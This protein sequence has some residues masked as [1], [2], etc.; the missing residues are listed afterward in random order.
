MENLC[1]FV[2]RRISLLKVLLLVNFGCRTAGRSAASGNYAHP[3]EVNQL[4]APEAISRGAEIDPGSNDPSLLLLSSGLWREESSWKTL[5]WESTDAAVVTAPVARERALAS[6][7][8]TPTPVQDNPNPTPVPSSSDLATPGVLTVPPSPDPSTPLPSTSP[9][10]TPLPSTAPPSTSPPSPAPTTSASATVS[11]PAPDPMPT[12]PATTLSPVQI[13]AT[14]APSEAVVQSDD[15]GGGGPDKVG[16]WSGIVEHIGNEMLNPVYPSTLTPGAQVSVTCRRIHGAIKRESH[17][18]CY[19]LRAL[20]SSFF[21]KL[22]GNAEL[23][24]S[25]YICLRRSGGLY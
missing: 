9:P 13:A 20:A 22:S 5:V 16:P 10:S 17:V 2:C 25:L 1:F 12:P 4:E 6:S 23:Q 15:M 19:S 21:S 24:L 3:P 11:T 14:P 7:S 8:A 18:T